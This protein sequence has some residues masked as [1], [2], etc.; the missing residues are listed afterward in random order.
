MEKKL[1]KIVIVRG[2]FGMNPRL[3][4]KPRLTV[5]EPLTYLVVIAFQAKLR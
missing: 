4:R 2:P 3:P 1:W 5:W